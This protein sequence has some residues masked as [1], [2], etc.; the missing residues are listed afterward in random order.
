V[1]YLSDNK[2][3]A[4]TEIILPLLLPPSED[5]I[6]KTLL[7][8]PKSGPV[9]RD[10]LS[11]VLGTTITSA[12]VRH[13]E[14]PIA[15]IH[16]K[17]E[18]FDVNCLTGGG[19]QVCVE[20]QASTMQGDNTANNYANIKSRAIY[21]L[22]DIHGKQ[23]A[24][25]S[26]YDKLLH[27]F[28][29]TICDYTV[30]PGRKDF[31]NRFSFRNSEGD[32]LID[33]VG[34]IFVELTKL[35]DIM[36][37]EPEEMTSLEMWAIFLKHGNNPKHRELLKKICKEREEIKVAME[38]LENISSDPDQRAM[39]LS[40]RKFEMDM[41]HNLSVSHEEGAAEERAKWQLIVADKDTALANKDAALANRD[42]EIERLRALLEKNN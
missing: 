19:E 30:F 24:M 20:M 38:L 29:V 16:E 2:P 36:K 9:L 40:R 4:D 42:A 41:G 1:A 31:V 39:F 18:R 7:S 5:G 35:A 11:A 22:C 12:T 28:Q 26:R 8:S 6:F 23:E 32:A 17:R 13:S 25:G 21:Y 10:I 33:T 27:S 34:I 37:K 3:P 14:P 15:D